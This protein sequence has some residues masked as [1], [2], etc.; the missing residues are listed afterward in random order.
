MDEIKEAIW[1]YNSDMNGSNNDDKTF[2]TTLK[3]HDGT[4]KELPI[5]KE[6]TDE[7]R[8]IRR[9]LI[10]RVNQRK[11]RE[12]LRLKK[13][14]KEKVTIELYKLEK[15]LTSYKDAAPLHRGTLTSI[16]V[17]IALMEGFHQSFLYHRQGAK[18]V[19][20]STAAVRF[21]EL[22]L[23]PVAYFNKLNYGDSELLQT[24]ID[25][26]FVPDYVAHSPGL[27]YEI[28][29]ANGL[30]CI[31]EHS[32]APVYKSTCLVSFPLT[33]NVLEQVL[34]D[35]CAVQIKNFFLQKEYMMSI[36]IE[37]EFTIDMSLQR[38][39]QI[40]LHADTMQ[41]WE[42]AVQQAILDVGTT[43]TTEKTV[44]LAN[45]L[46]LDAIFPKNGN[47]MLNAVL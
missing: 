43:T 10:C 34:S 44:F 32:S 17:A 25:S 16:G 29:D 30:R 42:T 23:T 31:V 38:I 35:K 40:N 15:T 7:E 12:R 37:C 36:R 9:R 26:F 6:Y 21:F 47:S 46:K 11:Y 20:G 45:A 24:A 41:A 5:K 28:S 19:P 33:V 4:I 1:L 3:L 8:I 27:E 39:A 14:E 22:L 2:V 18:M 13:S